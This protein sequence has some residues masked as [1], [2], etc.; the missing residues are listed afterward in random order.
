MVEQLLFSIVERYCSFPFRLRCAG[1]AVG[2][3]QQAEGELWADERLTRMDQPDDR[4][5]LKTADAF[6][7]VAPLRRAVRASPRST[8]SRAM[9]ER[10][11]CSRRRPEAMAEQ[12]RHFR[13]AC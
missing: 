3:G 13:Q 5:K 7:D 1:R 12:P 4:G 9:S 11:A 8:A 2:I 10:R 6:E